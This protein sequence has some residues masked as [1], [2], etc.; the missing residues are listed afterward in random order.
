VAQQDAGAVAARVE[1]RF[2][3]WDDWHELIVLYAGGRT[4]RPG[5]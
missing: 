4:A 1:V 5:P 2:R 3:A